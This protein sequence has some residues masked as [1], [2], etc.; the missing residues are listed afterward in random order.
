MISG[1]K[2]GTISAYLVPVPFLDLTV[3]IKV[4]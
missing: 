4:L 2:S 1:M 3:L